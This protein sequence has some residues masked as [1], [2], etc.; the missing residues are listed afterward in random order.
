MNTAIRKM[1][2]GIQSFEDRRRGQYV[3]VDKTARVYQLVTMEKPYFLS[4]PRR[5]GKSLLLSTLKAYF[6]GKK[7]LRASDVDAFMDRLRAFFA[8]IPYELNDK[9]ERH[10]QVIFYLV[11]KLMGQ[12]CETEVRSAKGRADAVVK[13][14]DYLYRFEFKLNGTAEEAIRQMDYPVVSQPIFKNKQKHS[15]SLLIR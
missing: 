12:F 14:A 3:Y 13:T 1:P 5:F 6:L 10:Y 4:R 8:D 7:E 15:L 9:T 11:F 2:I